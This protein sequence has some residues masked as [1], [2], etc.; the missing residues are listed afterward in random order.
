MRAPGPINQQA[1]RLG[2]TDHAQTGGARRVSQLALRQDEGFVSRRFSSMGTGV[3]TGRSHVARASGATLLLLALILGASIFGAMHSSSEFPSWL[4]A[5]ATV[6][7][8][9]A[10]GMAVGFAAEAYALERRRDDRWE[11]ERLQSQ[12]A[13]VAA[14]WGTEDGKPV[15]GPWAGD[16]NPQGPL[17]RNASQLPIREVLLLIWVDGERVASAQ[18]WAVIP[19]GHGPRRVR[20]SDGALRDMWLKLD[21]DNSDPHGFVDRVELAVSFI[22]SAEHRWARG[23]GGEFGRVDDI[24]VWERQEL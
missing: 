14:W 11:E 23:R 5:I 17:V 19:P 2:Q 21:P 22:D 1:G 15:Q 3:S 18:R 16:K 20:L 7:A 4:E 6:A 24:A 13:M 8:F 9:L 10:A 12:A